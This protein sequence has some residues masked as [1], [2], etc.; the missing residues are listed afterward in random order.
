MRKLNFRCLVAVLALL[1]LGC[2]AQADPDY[3]GE[4]L[5]TIHGRVVTGDHPPDQGMEAALIWMRPEPGLPND[6]FVV[7]RQRV[8]GSFPADFTLDVLEPPPRLYGEQESSVNGF[9]AAIP[10]QTSRVFDRYS[11]ILGVAENAGVVYFWEDSKAPG[12]EV[13][14]EAANLRVPPT[15]GYHLFRSEVTREREA[16]AYRCN[17]DDLCEQKVFSARNHSPAELLV[18][19][20]REDAGYARCLE[21]IPGAQTCTLYEAPSNAEEQAETDRCDALLDARFE[22]QLAKGT[23]CPPPWVRLEN[24]EGFGHRVTITLGRNVFDALEPLFHE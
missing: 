7:G 5:A 1:P 10:A 20:G 13:A 12:D 21:Y 23:D 19:Q 6:A 9:I 24:P 18:W 15:K 16:E 4:P 14:I 8:S 17:F 3:R 11:S 22:R 2:S